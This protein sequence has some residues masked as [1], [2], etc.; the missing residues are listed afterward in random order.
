M[1]KRIKLCGALLAT[2]LASCTFALFGNTVLASDASNSSKGAEELCKEL[3]DSIDLS[4]SEYFPEVGDQG[5]TGSCWHFGTIYACLTYANNKA[6][7]IKTTPENTLSPLFGYNYAAGTKNASLEDLIMHIGY[8]TVGILPIDT[9]NTISLYPRAEVWE[10][11]QRNRSGKYISYNVFGDEDNIVTGPDDASLYILKKTLS[12]GNPAAIS[13]YSYNWNLS[14]VASGEHKGE[15]AIDRCDLNQTGG[16]IIALVGYDDNIWV[17]I[18]H[19]GK[20]QQAE[21]GAFKMINSWGKDWANDGF[22][23]VTYDCLNEKSQVITDAD[24]TR[25]NNAIAAGTIKANKV[26]NAVRRSFFML[27]TFSNAVVRDRI[28]SECFLYM[29]V[30]TGS[31]REMDVAITATNKK[32]GTK[33]TYVMPNMYG[34]NRDVAWDG[35]AYSTDGTMV[36]D[37][38][39]VISDI[40]PET[41]E[42]YTWEVSFED[43]TLDEYSL[44]VK[45][46]YFTV[47]GVRKYIT[48]VSK[49]PLNGNERTYKMSLR[50]LSYEEDYVIKEENHSNVTIFY[51]NP[52]F[53]DCNIHY[54]V[55]DGNWTVA[56]GVQM[57]VDNQ[58]PEYTWKYVINLGDEDGITF[59]FNNG[60]DIWDNNSNRDY[61]I[62]QAGCYGIIDGNLEVIEELIYV[63]DPLIELDKQSI[64]LCVGDNATVVADVWPNYATIFKIKW[65]SS[66]TSVV[67]VEDGVITGVSQG[68]ATVTATLTEGVTATVN[69]TVNARQIEELKVT[70]LSDKEY[71]SIED[72]LTISATATGGDGDYKYSFI[73]KNTATGKWARLADKIEL[74][75]FVWT[76]GSGGAREFY[77]E[78]TDGTG[79]TV[80]SSAIKVDVIWDSTMLAAGLKA[81]TTKVSVGDK[82]MFT[83]MGIDGEGSYKYSYIVYNKTTKKWAR[84]ADK[85]T[86][87]TFTWEA[88]SAGTRLFYVDVT[89]ASGQTVRSNAITVVTGNQ[90]DLSVKGQASAANVSVG[91]SVTITG[92]AIGVDGPYTYSFVVYNKATNKWYRHKFSSSNV[93][94]WK[95][96]SKG[97]RLFYIEAKDKNGKVVR[98]EAVKI[99]VK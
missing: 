76:A 26:N 77:V 14:E 85:I 1:K 52:D 99:T 88:I 51:S 20:Q 59:C 17:D 71:V 84:L 73:I 72:N 70:A 10:S 33:T 86:S 66:D 61:T 97:T 94:D 16:H 92:T 46:L 18:N 56:P 81:N 7:D 31:R 23:W 80:R 75:S 9:K 30:N 64:S 47:N 8:P 45:D 91:G 90:S 32:D 25:I 89:D 3:P 6:R 37:L 62:R 57:C 39:N 24:A 87:D 27:K 83:A 35:T 12:E 79:K 98:S 96:T 74:N 42:D 95:A 48:T 55:G 93:L 49:L 5:S 22:V 34:E 78:V 43:D 15:V 4:K 63:P 60:E 21:L 67:K 53:E 13:S 19:D 40:T 28:S 65:T 82:V 68:K 69:V 41:M 36:L 50:S 38:D 29:T 2:A 54:R 44:T 11:A 58:R